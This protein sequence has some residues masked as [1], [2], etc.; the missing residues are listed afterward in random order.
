MVVDDEQ[1]FRCDIEDIGCINCSAGLLPYER[2]GR[3]V[4]REVGGNEDIWVQKRNE[5]NKGAGSI[6]DRDEAIRI[7]LI[8]GVFSNG[9]GAFYG[10]G[11]GRENTHLHCCIWHDLYNHCSVTVQFSSPVICIQYEYDIGKFA[12]GEYYL[13]GVFSLTYVGSFWLLASG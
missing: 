1:S 12:V 2:A 3:Y 13:A 9:A 4:S 6:Q 11:G 5:V 7:D 10:E 8:P